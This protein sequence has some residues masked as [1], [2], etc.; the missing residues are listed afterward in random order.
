M[1]Y[2][3]TKTKVIWW[4]KAPSELERE[5]KPKGWFIV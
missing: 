2:A 5:V 3:N 1:G 4:T